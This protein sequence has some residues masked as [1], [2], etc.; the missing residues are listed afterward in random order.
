MPTERV[1]EAIVVKLP[2]TTFILPRSRHVPKPKPL[3]K[4]QEFAKTKG[5][6]KKK[7][8][9]LTWDEQ[10]KKWIPLYGYKRAA[11]QKEKDWVVEVPQ[12]ADP[13]ED[14]FAKKADIKSEKV[15]KNELQRLRNIAK[16][17]KIKVP[18]VGFTNPDISSSK[19]VSLNRKSFKIFYNINFQ[20]QSAVTV[21]RSSTVSLGKTQQKLPNEK[22]ARGIASITPG[23]SRKRKLPPVSGTVEREHNL[24]VIDSVLN[25]RPKINIEQAVSNQLRTEY[26]SS[27]VFLQDFI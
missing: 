24:S 21:A 16:A 19:D 13:M 26:V 11:A 22:E 17:R 3:S 14:Q 10:L 8:S 27:I 5:I 18:R 12:N 6:Q 9:K 20:L 7:K 23:A 4:W 2:P 25:K 1:E 15:A